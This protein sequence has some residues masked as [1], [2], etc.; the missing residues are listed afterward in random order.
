[1]LVYEQI[2]IKLI[3]QE[4]YYIIIMEANESNVRYSLLI[5]QILEIEVQTFASLTAFTKYTFSDDILKMNYSSYLHSRNTGISRY[6][7]K[8]KKN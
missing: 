2:T 7:L 8:I 3:T 1:M 6:S 5:A 4:L